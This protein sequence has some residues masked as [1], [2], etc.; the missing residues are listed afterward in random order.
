MS[1]QMI[2]VNEAAYEDLKNRYYV[3]LVRGDRLGE[4]NKRLKEH[5]EALRIIEH[6]ALIYCEAASEG[7]PTPKLDKL[8][9]D[10]VDALGWRR[11]TTERKD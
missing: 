3:W 8:F 7:L 2:Q 4:E 9:T 5:N 11:K 6:C 1:G 10:L